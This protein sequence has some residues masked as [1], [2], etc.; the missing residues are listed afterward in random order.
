M[1]A[2]LAL[3]LSAGIILPV[4]GMMEPSFLQPGML[5]FS[6]GIILAFEL[7]SLRRLFAVLIS[8]LVFIG[9]MV[10][11][12]SGDGFQ[13]IS[14]FML[15]LTLRLQGIRTSL[16]LVA[17][18]AQLIV[19]CVL[20]AVCCFAV[21][22]Q[23]TCI[24]SVLLATGTAFLIWISDRTELTPWFLPAIAA[25]LTMIMISRFREMPLTRIVPWAA[26]I[27]A[28]SFLL[29]GGGYTAEPLKDK[30]DEYRQAIMDRLFFTEARDVFSLY[31]AGFS[32]QGPD[33]L[34]GKPTPD[35]HP[36]M[37]VSTSRTTYL[38]GTVYDLYNG[39]GWKN[40]AG[41]RRFLWQSGRMES[42]KV[43]LFNQ[44]LPPASVQNSLSTESVVSVRILNDG[45]STLFVPQRVRELQPGGEM[46]PYFSNSSEIFITR[47]VQ[48]GDTYTVVAPLFTSGDPGI[49]SLIEICSARAD[50]ERESLPPIYLELP[51]HLEQPLY[52]LVARITE[53]AVTPYERAMAIQNWLSRNCRYT[54]DVGEHPENVDFVTSFVMETRKGY[55]TYFASAMTVLC[56]IA[57]LP[58]RYVEGY[59]AEPNDR[60]EAIV[61]GME[62]HAW[63]E[64]YFEG[65]GWL[66]FDATP[67]Q[68]RTSGEG[69]R[70]SGNEQQTPTPE[71]EKETPVPEPE[72]ET[73]TPEPENE[74]PENETPTPQPENETPVPETENE[75]NESETPTPEPEKEPPEETPPPE[76]LPET[77]D[78][79]DRS[80][81]HPSGFPWLILLLLP[82]VALVLR[83]FMTSP[84]FCSRRAQNEERKAGIWAQEI[85]DMLSAEKMLRKKGETLTGFMRRVDLTGIFDTA[86]TPA[87]ECLS[88]L[89]YSRAETLETDTGMLRDTAV[90]LKSEISKSAR[91]KYWM[92]RIFIPLKHRRWT[93]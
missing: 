43:L 30:A 4:L 66:T 72:R 1:H 80:P 52:E 62:A 24:P 82:L 34:G 56:R 74:P 79:N 57:G 23:A 17:D 13:S 90:L 12:L 93:R 11:V 3:M 65:F 7:A 81:N 49:G 6:V 89:M 35:E 53:G 15:A 67:K 40:T 8:V 50:P 28:I 18:T 38:R 88:V 78:Q 19:T 59:L 86:L 75:A 5:L 58:A 83:I 51:G 39:H 60:G 45:T 32:P 54:L 68:R 21:L 14:D 69:N 16:P 42:E 29:T 44:E 31:V 71:P 73:P 91:L 48:A 10:W 33:Q 64:V 87:G 46:V 63:T 22:R 61:T 9:G 55:C 26:V 47:N 70:D 27:T 20:S 41:G 25:T 2:L 92:R 85:M 76:N 36:V 77:T 37:Q 84:E